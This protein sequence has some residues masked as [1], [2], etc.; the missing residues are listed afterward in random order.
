M[1]YNSTTGLT[2]TKFLELLDRITEILESRTCASQPPGGRP[3]V[4]SLHD[5]LYIALNLLRHN[6]RQNLLAHLH[7]VSQ[8]TVSRAYRRMLPL[9]SEA[10]AFELPDIHDALNRG[11]SLIIDGTDVPVRKHKP[12]IR[13][14]YSGKK[15]K[16]CVNVEVLTTISG[17][18]MLLAEPVPGSHHDRKAMTESGLEEL[19]A[20]TPY[21]GDLGYQGT[22]AMIPYKKG[23]RPGTGELIKHDKAFN[24]Q[25]A[26]I[27][28]AVEQGIS[29]LKNWKI[30]AE[31]Y[32]G[33][34]H[35][36][37]SVIQTIGRLEFFRLRSLGT[38]L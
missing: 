17:R 28:W 9:I 1:N 19:L 29:H 31:I 30:M 12:A 10:L 11:E 26:K 27:R 37:P 20:A 8:P 25:L 6:T 18:L 32:R 5:Q 3:V 23:Q 34:F 16:H 36:L 35:E 14:H 24:D 13:T 21:L 4:L 33:V 7:G 15:R 22:D 38:R 2:L